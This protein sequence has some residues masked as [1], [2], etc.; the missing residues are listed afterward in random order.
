M[1]PLGPIP[2]GYQSID[3]ELAVGGRKFSEI[4]A[5]SGTPL[6][7]YSRALIERR[8]ADL[9]AAM[10]PTLKIHYAVKANPYAPVLELVRR[11]ADGFDIAS[12]RTR[13]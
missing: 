12:G 13:R 8:M 9:R 7:V 6:F 11:L 1:K 5:K 4:E 3:G 10:P 2:E